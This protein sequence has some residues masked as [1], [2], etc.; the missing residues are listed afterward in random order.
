MAKGQAEGDGRAEG[1]SATGDGRQA[2]T[3]CLILTGT[4]SGS[5]LDSIVHIF[6]SSH[7]EGLYVGALLYFGNRNIC[8]AFSMA[9][10]T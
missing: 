8:T 2:A 10:S 1:L 9:G 6:E 7:L 3:L 4:G 5:S